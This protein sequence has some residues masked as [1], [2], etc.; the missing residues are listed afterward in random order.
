MAAAVACA[1][2]RPDPCG[3]VSGLA[4]ES[5]AAPETI[6]DVVGALDEVCTQQQVDG[7]C[8]GEALLLFKGSEADRRRALALV[9]ASCGRKHDPSC[10]EKADAYAMGTGTM[11]DEAKAKA[12]YDQYCAGGNAA[13]C[14]QMAIYANLG[15]DYDHA[16]QYAQK[17]CDGSNAEGCNDLGYLYFT[18]KGTLHDAAK[19]IELWDRSCT[20]D[21]AYGCGN[22]GYMARYGIGRP[23]DAK[24]AFAYYQK[25]CRPTAEFGCEGTG[26]YYETG[27]GVAKDLKK[28][29]DNY[30]LA[31]ES[32]T[33][34]YA[35]ACSE[36]AALYE[37]N[38]QGSPSE[39]ARLRE[40][41]F[42]VATERAK[43]NPFSMYVL[44]TYYRDGIATVKDPAKAREWFAKGC[45]GFDPLACLN[46]GK[47]FYA[48]GDHEHGTTYAQ[49]ACGTGLDEACK[50]GGGP[51][52]GEV[53]RKGCGCSGGGGDG[54]GA[55]IA[56]VM[57][58][59]AVP[60]RRRAR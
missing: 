38:H 59:L 17:A 40:K 49:R 6:K 5:T 11:K 13:A 15:S 54:G 46:A 39:I 42:G 50:L 22:M 19:G 32:Q 29:V 53:Q 2:G 51:A 27:Q 41:A 24:Q 37:A 20:L 14:S 10:L 21:G 16:L 8:Y 43:D 3:W 31:C 25:A 48:I 23:L 58:G 44:A 34:P 35:L 45:D 12:I 30:K 18:G 47:E 26:Y 55:V 1:Y 57:V 60:R 28:A 9:D 56:I 36:L 7:A 4:D 52:A 33:Q